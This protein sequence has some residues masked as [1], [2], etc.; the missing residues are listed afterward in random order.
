M[1]SL[2]GF[3]QNKAVKVEKW[4]LNKTEAKYVLTAA[5]YEIRHS[6]AKQFEVTVIIKEIPP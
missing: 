6:G 5:L 3:W 1:S 2:D 4:L